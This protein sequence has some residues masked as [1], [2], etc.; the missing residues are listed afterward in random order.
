LKI[1]FEVS[2]AKETNAVEFALSLD[3]LFV[4]AAECPLELEP[5]FGAAPG[6]EFIEQNNSYLI[7]GEAI[8][9]NDLA[10]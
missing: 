8:F 6:E 1:I 4:R 9:S 2:K 7:L 5:F 3:N 10:D